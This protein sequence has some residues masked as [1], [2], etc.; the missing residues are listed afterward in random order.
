MGRKSFGKCVSL[1]A[2]L[3]CLAIAPSARAACGYVINLYAPTNG[4]QYTAPANVTLTA[5]A[6]G[7]DDGCTVLQVKFYNGATLLGQVGRNSDGLFTYTW[8]GVPAGSYVVKA[9]TGN[10]AAMDTASITVYSGQNLAPSISMSTPTGAPFIAAA[11]IGL[12]ASASDGDG[13]ISRV[14]FYQGTNLVATDA[15]APYAA[16]YTASSAGT[17][18]F[19]AKATDNR[20]A[21][22]TT[23][24]VTVAVAANVLP[25]VSLTAPANGASFVSPTTIPI[26]AT[27]SDS[28]GSIARVEFRANGV[29]LTSDTTAPYQASWSTGNIGGTF[30]ITA[31]AIDNKGG[32]R[33]TSVN[34]TVSTPVGSLSASPNPCTIL[35][36]DSCDTTVSWTSNDPAAQIWRHF[37]VTIQTQEGPD[38]R[39]S[40]TLVGSGTSGSGTFDIGGAKRNQYFEL[41]SGGAAI[42][43]VVPSFN[44][45]PSTTITAPA[46][47]AIFNRPAN[48]LISATGNDADGSVSKV[49]FYASGALIGTDTTSPFAITWN[50]VPSGSHVLTTRAYDNRGAFRDSLPITITGNTRPTVALTSPATGAVVAA[51]TNVSVRAMAADADDGVAMV[52]FYNGAVKVGT[53]IEAPYEFQWNG[54]PSGTYSLTAKAYDTRGGATVSSVSMLVVDDVP[55][56]SLTAPAAGTVINAPGSYTLTASASDSDGAINRVE[57]YRGSTLIG[58]DAAAPYSVLWSDIVAGTYSITAKAYDDRGLSKV[59]SSVTFVANAQPSVTI[60]S[61]TMDAVVVAPADVLIQTSASD[62]DDGVAMVEFYVN[63]QLRATDTAAP[64]TLQADNMPAGT[65]TLTAKAYDNRGGATL[66][67]PTTLV[68]NERPQVQVVSPSNN[69]GVLVPRT[70]TLAATASDVDGTISRVEFYN[71]GSLLGSVTSAPYQLT[72]N[73]SAAGDYT[74]T[75]RAYDNRGTATTSAPS[76]LRA[77]VNAFDLIGDAQA[78]SLSAELPVHDATVGKVAGQPGVVGGAAT[79]SVPIAI[80]PGR[81]GM[82]PELSL[83]YN[84]RSGSGIAGMGWSLSGV[85]SITRC[86]ATLDQDG[87]IRVVELGATDKLCLDGQRL[88]NTSGVY[89]QAG[90]TYATEIDSFSRIT[91]MGGALNSAAT[92]FML[93]TKSG[94]IIFYGGNSTA[95]SPARVI[96]GGVTLPLSWLIERRQDRIGNFVRYEYVSYGNGEAL[97]SAI[98]Y[99]G[100]GGTDGDRRVEF[101]YE[102]RPTVAGTNDQT[103]AYVAGGLTRQTQRLAKIVTKVAAQAV[104]EYRLTYQ[105]SGASGRSLLASVTEC[106]FFN[107]QAVCKPPTTFAWQSAP[108]THRFGKISISPG[109]NVPNLKWEFATSAGGGDFNGDGSHDVFGIG[110][111][112]SNPNVR[113]GYL[114]TLSPERQITAAISISPDSPLQVYGQTADFDLDGRTDV[115]SYDANKNIVISFWHGPANAVTTSEAL[116]DS[117]NT[118]VGDAAG[119]SLSHITDMDG[120]ARPDL[121]LNRSSASPTDSCRRV[122]EVYLNKPGANPAAPATFVKLN[123]TI[124][125]RSHWIS[126]YVIFVEKVDSIS[127]INGDGLPEIY[128]RS[129][130]YENNGDIDR[131]FYGCRGGSICGGS[132]YT[133][134]ET[135]ANA[136]LPVTDPRA[137]YADGIKLGATRQSDINGDGLSDWFAEC[138][139]RLNTGKGYGPCGSITGTVSPSNARNIGSARAG[140]A[141]LNGDGRTETLVPRRYAAR[142]CQKIVPDCPIGD[143][144]AECEVNYACPEDLATGTLPYGPYATFS[145]GFDGRIKG[146]YNSGYGHLDSS[147]YYMNARRYIEVG[148][149]QY[150]VEEFQTSIVSGLNANMSDDLFGDGLVD[151]TTRASCMFSDAGQCAI[152]IA[153][154]SGNPISATDFPRSLPDGS[155]LFSKDIFINENLGPGGA[156]S[157]NGVTPQTPD[158]MAGVVDGLG[159]QTIWTYYPLSSKAGRGAGETPLYTVPSDSASRYID[160]RHFYFTSSMPVVSDMIQTDGTG[161]YRSWR[162]G[163]GEAMYHARGRGFQ[164]FRSII[165]EDE[166]A[167]TRTTTTFHQKFPLTSQPEQIVVNSLRRSGTD[168]PISKQTFTWRCNRANRADSSACTPPSGTAKV[169]FP[170]LDAKETWTYDAAIADNPSAGAP[171]AVSYSVDVNAD[172]PTCTGSYAVA[173]GFDAY[174]NL[175]AHTTHVR[176]V[177]GGTGGFRA[178]LGDRCQRE[179]SQFTINPAIWWVDRLDQR[180]VITA[181]IVWDAAQHPLPAGASNTIQTVV[182]LYTWNADRTPDTQTLQPGV[183]NQQRVTAYAYPTSSNFGQPIGVAVSAD[184]DSNGTRSTGVAY[185]A[186][187]YFQRLVINSLEQGVLTETRASD[188]Q[189]Y[190]VVDANGL[191]TLMQYDAFGTLIRTQFRGHTDA[192][193]RAPDKLVA[194][195]RCATSG[196]WQTGEVYQVTTVQDG[197][198]TTL[199]RYDVLGRPR[200]QAERQMDGAFTQVAL[201]YN[202]RGQVLRQ[203]EPFR[204]DETALYWTQFTHYDVLGRLTRKVAPQRAEDNRGDRVTTYAYSGR[205]TSIQVCGTADSGTAKCLNLSRTVDSLGRYVETRDANG[206]RTR[207]WYDAQGNTLALEDA[208]GVVTRA[209][210]N[211][212]GQRTSVA[213]PNQGAWNFAYNALGELL[214]QVDARG[215][216]TEF[217]YDKLGRPLSRAATVD[218]TGDGAAETVLDSWAYDP[219]NALGQEASNQ[220]TINGTLERRTATSYDALSRAVQSDIVQAMITGTQSYRTRQKYDS[221]YGRPVGQEYPNGEAVEFVYSAYG[222]AL[223]ERDPATGVVYRTLGGTNARGQPTLETFGNTLQTRPGYAV[224]TGQVTELLQQANGIEVRRLGYGYDVYG[225]LTRQTLNGGQSEETYHYDA[226]HRLIDSTRIGAATGTV[227]YGYDAVGNVTYKSDFSLAQPTAYAYGGGSCGGGPNA[228]KSVLTASGTRTYCYDANGNLTS[229]SHGLSL[230]YDHMN[231]PVVAQRA[232]ARDDFRYGPNG[233]RVRSW[234]SDGS[235]VYLP[236]YEHRIDTGETKVYVGDYAVIT[237]SG[238]T[239]KIDYL[240]K[241]RL[242]SVDAIANATGALT[243]TRGY[244]AFGKPRTGTWADLSPA[245]LQSTGVTPKGFTQHEHLNSLELIH[246][247]G[248]VFDYNLGRFTGVDPVIQFPLNS[249]SLNPYSYILNSPLSGTD[250]TGYK[251][252]EECNRRQSC[253]MQG[254]ML[255]D[256]QSEVNSMAGEMG[257]GANSAGVTARR[258]ARQS[259]GSVSVG[260]I[261]AGSRQEQSSASS[262]KGSNANG[263]VTAHAVNDAP[264]AP[265]EVGKYK[266]DLTLSSADEATAVAFIKG[267]V[268][269]SNSSTEAYSKF[270]YGEQPG[271]IT[272]QGCTE[273]RCPGVGNGIEIHWHVAPSSLSIDG[274]KDKGWT[275]GQLRLSREFP[276][277]GD[278]VMLNY[279]TINIGVTPEGGAWAIERIRGAP[280]MR[281]LISSPNVQRD[282]WIRSTWNKHG[283]S[284]RSTSNMMDMIEKRG[285]AHEVNP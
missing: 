151:G 183:A 197:S 102:T 271:P 223:Q 273:A 229:D 206:G 25:A 254:N 37:D 139:I 246:M 190:L 184:G 192:E 169:M 22:A 143:D 45:R 103:S 275:E 96:P 18:S 163:Y 61:P 90:T 20:G 24:P 262:A 68:V 227:T 39:H 55:T 35:T 181:P 128:I 46:N 285:R 147:L 83:D 78:T 126:D 51:P 8:S 140:S 256:L 272:S 267:Q 209:S 166:A 123:Q 164:G 153:D 106:G 50:D 134:L 234:G 28:D 9:V 187:G 252:R 76:L 236:G 29:L 69:T 141:D 23:A 230:K 198:P 173:S 218:V 277:P 177:G 131:Y 269:D 62:T 79:Y 82:Q 42:T 212:I 113:L 73:A 235:R 100:F 12:S 225:N 284:L 280:Q 111:D 91:Q 243:E 30:P 5:D 175:T 71:G 210:Y 174:G 241:D 44:Y 54:V 132:S 121:V 117:W 186:D 119:F 110:T 34:V 16:T 238:S 125:L 217:A 135:D 232:G 4:A 109:A 74:F 283:S 99:T 204:N 199:V 17:Y 60:T 167:G 120:D 168:A 21:T 104:R 216:V 211:A 200:L 85:S 180:T 155:A 260:P 7:T 93:E 70:I 222:H 114:L 88:V 15:V 248:R 264:K 47:G 274:G 158:L 247:N 253:E 237:R 165:E 156:M 249:Q 278:H 244:D 240:L 138:G 226:L 239:R 43:S 118:G 162:Y 36:G 56:V 112:P 80:P 193:Y 224:T 53:D 75:A 40:A 185:S 145:S 105:I 2:L 115:V 266:G 219:V 67:S 57:F 72:W 66:S 59:T 231:L 201:E 38:E 129:D 250:P 255:N 89:G 170:F 101:S 251:S 133:L 228:V 127:D 176:D 108:I 64:F 263:A 221:Y 215:I 233:Q 214:S 19:T 259:N 148:P 77:R 32:A 194:V 48:V 182:N 261:G 150:R 172:D 81:R 188:G 92:Y 265:W 94:E 63:G 161:D 270:A 86:P 3:T 242:G 65:Y 208:N 124:C 31:T 87:V 97:L 207:F 27:A 279:G 10:G 282:D 58:V 142:Y 268:Y 14:D 98:L 171:P 196:C 41:T 213:D 95:A 203:S 179:L 195:S 245:R 189:P 146:L 191:R 149:S 144:R 136:A 6:D 281:W 26:S 49:E 258:E 276:G 107:G 11:N 205:Q 130:G 13:T 220:R 33:S 154:A 160:D 178:F 157:P 84:S 52:E 116:T 152:P 159:A 137:A 122:V 1:L 257:A 202:A